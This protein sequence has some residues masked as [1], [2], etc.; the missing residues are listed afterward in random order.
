MLSRIEHCDH[1]WVRNRDHRSRGFEEALA[2]DRALGIARRQEAD[3]DRAAK[4]RV[5]RPKQLSRSC[6]LETFEQIVVSDRTQH[7]ATTGYGSVV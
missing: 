7:A 1:V 3:G 6:G 5:A 2:I 4:P